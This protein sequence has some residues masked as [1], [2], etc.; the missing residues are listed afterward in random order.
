MNTLAKPCITCGEPVRGASYCAD[1]T[2]HDNT[3]KSRQARGYGGTWPRLSK[4]ARRI[5]PWCSDCGATEDLTAD[6]SA[7][8]WRRHAAGKPI[9]LEDIDV[10]C[11]R[12]NTARGRQRPD[13]GG[14]PAPAKGAP[15]RQGTESISNRTVVP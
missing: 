11:R 1:H 8:A 13:Q 7:E 14:H 10:V 2:P 3:P 9:R 12:C 4:R 15:G 5:Q 6:H